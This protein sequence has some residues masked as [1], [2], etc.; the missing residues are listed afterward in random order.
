MTVRLPS[1]FLFLILVSHLVTTTTVV[2]IATDIVNDKEN[3]AVTIQDINESEILSGQQER[4]ELYSSKDILEK[5]DAEIDRNI[6]GTEEDTSS[7]GTTD[8]PKFSEET[9]DDASN[10][11][12]DSS[13][14]INENTDQKEAKDS[15]EKS[16][17][18]NLIE[19][20]IGSSESIQNNTEEKSNE[21]LDGSKIVK[22]GEN[23]SLS[24]KDKT[25]DGSSQKSGFITQK[26]KEEGE[27]EEEKDFIT[28]SSTSEDSIS[29]GSDLED[30]IESL[31]T[32]LE[33]EEA[34]SSS[35]SEKT[36]ISSPEVIAK[37]KD[38]EGGSVSSLENKSNES[39]NISSSSSTMNTEHDEIPINNMMN[40]DSLKKPP[41]PQDDAK[42]ADNIEE[43]EEQ[44]E[45]A[46][47]DNETS[48]D[49]QP[50]TKK[51]T[52]E[53]SSSFSK[54][55]QK[56]PIYNDDNAKDDTYLDLD[57][58]PDG[59]ESSVVKEGIIIEEDD[60][61]SVIIEDESNQDVNREVS[62]KA[63][64]R[65]RA[66]E[67]RRFAETTNTIVTEVPT[68]VTSDGY[69]G[70]P[71]GQYRSTRRLPD[72]E[73]LR[74]VFE[75]S[76]KTRENTSNG[77]M[78]SQ[79]VVNDWQH[80][81]L[82]DENIAMDTGVGEPILG[83]EQDP[84]FLEY[85]SRLLGAND[86]VAGAN[87]NIESKTGNDTTQE[88][89]ED[90]EADDVN[91]DDSNADV[92]SEFVEGLDDIDNFFE[93]VNPPDELDVG[94]GSSIQ[95]VLMDKGKHILLKKVRGAVRW[96][97][98]GWQVMGRKLEERISEFQLPFQKIEGTTSTASDI[99]AEAANSSKSV[100]TSAQRDQ[101]LKST[102]EA[103]VTA[104]KVGKQT[105]EVISDFVDG[106][107]DRFDDRGEED[108]ANF[109]DFNGFDLDN[110]SSFQPPV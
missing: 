89:K 109:D 84:K 33:S 82:Y 81:P 47:N 36:T 70:E 79:K 2:V 68:T 61:E 8:D 92:N 69:R 32:D 74:L 53:N 54:E 64:A 105:V 94:Y 5:E 1:I 55:S 101:L 71:W 7:V 22:T 51:E 108:S 39:G 35:S 17:T 26:L 14:S 97:K 24:S 16:T 91:T 107:L 93:G 65:A 13:S 48:P 28:S 4:E 73:L 77:D 56:S 9:S 43:E 52:D 34:S 6:D 30:E 110:L 12:S 50:N 75:N 20:M 80:D 96:I 42:I 83:D 90:G 66:R 76:N 95:D 58:P 46:T 38:T 87:Q 15:N 19:D 102:K 11:I 21:S 72:L 63:R 60:D 62:E 31:E 41:H 57:E 99:D 67:D 18:E 106:L 86:G 59:S 27:E 44:K 23:N 45:A 85:R 104:W 98:I 10:R 78:E 88:K 25:K 40:D 49:L 103:L 3:G 100:E 29:L 37:K